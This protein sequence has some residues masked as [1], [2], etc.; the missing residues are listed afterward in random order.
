VS[1]ELLPFVAFRAN[2]EHRDLRDGDEV[3]IF[4]VHGTSS[5]FVVFLDPGKTPEDVEEEMVPYNV[6][7]SKFDWS[8]IVQEL[9]KRAQY[10][11][12]TGGG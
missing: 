3:A 8:R 1:E 12:A 9:E 10:E 2:L 4:N 5:H 11:E 6:V 7:V